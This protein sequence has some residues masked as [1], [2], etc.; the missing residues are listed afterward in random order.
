[1][2]VMSFF[3]KYGRHKLAARYRTYMYYHHTGYLLVGLPGRHLMES[4]IHRFVNKHSE[5][6]PVLLKLALKEY[7]EMT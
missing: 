7:L 5:E 1:M 3:G 4:T 2:V 6:Q